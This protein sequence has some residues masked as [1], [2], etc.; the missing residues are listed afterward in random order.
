MKILTHILRREILDGELTSK[1]SWVEIAVSSHEE[2][3][4]DLIV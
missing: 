4:N 2:L 3:E 1:V